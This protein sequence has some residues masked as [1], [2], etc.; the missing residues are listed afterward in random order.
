MALTWDGCEWCRSPIEDIHAQTNHTIHTK[1]DYL[2]AYA[3]IR[4]ICGGIEKIPFIEVNTGLV[5]GGI[6]TKI[7]IKFCPNC[8]KKLT[9]KETEKVLEDVYENW[10]K[11]KK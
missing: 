7:E 8:G 5:E 3:D 2:K 10:R 11:T 9:D 1:G 6:H 4:L